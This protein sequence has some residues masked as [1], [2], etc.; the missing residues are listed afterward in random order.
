MGSLETAVEGGSVS[1]PAQTNWYQRLY[2]RI[3]SL[4]R[5]R[6]AY[7]ALLAVSVVDGSVFPIPPFALLVPMVL[8]QPKRWWSMSLA[9]TVASLGGGL[10][11]YYLG[12]LIHSGIAPPWV[13]T[14]ILAVLLGALLLAPVSALTNR[15]GRALRTTA[16]R[17]AVASV[18]YAGTG[19]VVLVAAQVLQHKLLAI[20]LSAPVN[21]LGI[22]ST[23]GQLLGDNFWVLSLLCSILPTP[24]KVVAIGSG[25]VGVPLG[26]FMLAAVI[27]RTVRFFGVGGFM[28]LFGPRARRW[29][30]V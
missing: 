9:G 10:V 6:Y 17:A 1:L 20:D 2:L 26:K 16:T 14:A 8:A 22:H 4:S 13:V 7:A 25:M 24:F 30:R 12:A 19:V 29:L 11:G 15:A 28:A 18:C 23:V 27:G 5:T 21:R 3:E